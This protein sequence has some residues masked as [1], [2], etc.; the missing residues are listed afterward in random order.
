MSREREDELVRQIG[1]LVLADCPEGWLRADLNV[2]VG[3]A[4]R[5]TI[6]VPNAPGQWLSGRPDPAID[7]LLRELLDLMPDRWEAMRLVVDPPDS[8]VVHFKAA[9]DASATP[10]E[11][12]VRDRLVFAL[13]PGWDWAQVR[14]DSGLLHMITG[15]TVPYTPPEGVVPPGKQVEMRHRE[16]MRIID[17]PE[18]RETPGNR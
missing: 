11:Q 15:E 2:Q 10:W 5:L 4:H 12:A 17:V 18:G 16:G 8:Y 14:H 9:G 6:L 1:A 13:P 7:P 3:Y